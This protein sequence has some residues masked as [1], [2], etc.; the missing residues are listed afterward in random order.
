[1]SFNVD[2]QYTASTKPRKK[3]VTHKADWK[4]FTYTLNI[5]YVDYQVPEFVQLF[6]SDLTKA[7]QDAAD[8]SIPTRGRKKHNPNKKYR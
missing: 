7:I 4:K 2:A 5:W 3:W 6:A 8:A 1:M